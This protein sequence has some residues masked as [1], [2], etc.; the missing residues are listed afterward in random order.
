MLNL[1]NMNR[2]R[3]LISQTFGLCVDIKFSLAHV[4]VRLIS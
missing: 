2:Q 3:A 4:T 1:G